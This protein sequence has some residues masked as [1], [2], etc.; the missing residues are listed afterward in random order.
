MKNMN[1][2]FAVIGLVMFAGCGTGPQGSQGPQGPSAAPAPAP[3]ES[4]V[5]LM[6]DKE[7]QYRLSVGQ[8]ALVSGLTC[9][10]YTVP[11]TTTAIIGATGLVTVGSFAYTGQFNQPN[12]PVTAGL[13]ILP[14]A[15]QGVYQTWFIVKCTGSLV[16]SDDNWHEFD[17]NSDDGA[18]LYVD[19][20]L[21]NNDGLHGAQDKAATKYLKYGIHSFEVDYFQSNGS[22]ALIVNED[23]ALM[24]SAGFYH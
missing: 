1:V 3:T 12:G 4:D 5:Q 17:I 13:N 19:G 11:T 18:N 2:I 6:V 14:T 24:S 7:N 10:L 22:E 9:T 16:V 8:E 21:I 23:N 20:L 15:L